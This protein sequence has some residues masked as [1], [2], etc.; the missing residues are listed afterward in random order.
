MPRY[1]VYFTDEW[2]N[3]RLAEFNAILDL[4]GL[5]LIVLDDVL[6][7]GDVDSGEG[8]GNG[9]VSDVDDEDLEGEGGEGGLSKSNKRKNIS[10]GSSCFISPFY[11]VELP[12]DD[13]A[14]LIC[15]R[16]VLVRAIYEVWSCGPS[17]AL[18]LERV[19]LTN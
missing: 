2:H 7:G 10:S 9:E 6:S 5:P 1:L 13:V 11:V 18:A 12:S 4:F 14:L 17:L 15:R 8:E 16:S 19:K 3:F